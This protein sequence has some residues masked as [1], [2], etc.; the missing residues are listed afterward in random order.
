MFVVVAVSQD[1]EASQIIIFGGYGKKLNEVINGRNEMK[2][3]EL[4]IVSSYI[5]HLEEKAIA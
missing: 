2:K 5:F 1:L 3:Y 4:K